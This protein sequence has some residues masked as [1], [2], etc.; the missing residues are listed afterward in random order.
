ML[1]EAELELRY[2]VAL[3]L[4]Q[5]AGALAMT[6]ANNRATMATRMKGP[7]DF[8]TEADGAVEAMLRTRLA[9]IFPNDCFVEI[10]RAHV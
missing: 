10:G 6:Y 3:G 7:Q 9:R 2:L 4:A 1:T 8:L 5:E